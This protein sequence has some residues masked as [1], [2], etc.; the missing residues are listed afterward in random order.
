MPCQSLNSSEAAEAVAA[1]LAASAPPLL[2]C[3]VSEAALAEVT[4]AL[5]AALSEGLPLE[6]GAPP[7]PQTPQQQAA[8]QQQAGLLIMLATMLRA[9][10]GAAVLAAPQLLS[11]GRALTAPGRLPLLLWALSQAAAAEPAAAVATWVRV[12][13]PQCL[14][15]PLPAPVPK[16]GVA[17]AAPAVPRMEAASVESAVAFLEGLLPAVGGAA[18]VA[19]AGAMEPAVPGSAAEALARAAAPPAPDAALAGKGGKGGGGAAAAAA[20]AA[21]ALASRLHAPL[22]SLAG[23]SRSGARG[24]S[25]WLVLA[26]ETASLS[27]AGGWRRMAC[28]GRWL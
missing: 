15:A 23:K 24:Q 10:P 14:G 13:L 18:D 7:P 2:R 17:A 19:V 21:E 3:Q 5:L 11:L 8:R 1:P 28:L 27:A 6:A 16:S 20:A 25:E 9:R 22:V 26:L 12:V 4:V